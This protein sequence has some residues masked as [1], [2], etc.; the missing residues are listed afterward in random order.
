M[1]LPSSPLKIPRGYVRG[2][3]QNYVSDA[4]E[5][6]NRKDIIPESVREILKS[7]QEM[8]MIIGSKP[9]IT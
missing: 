5:E 6:L 8:I 7:I 2:D 1:K 3:C 9:V 4:V